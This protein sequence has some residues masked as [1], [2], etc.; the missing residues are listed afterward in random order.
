[1]TDAK[2]LPAPW[3]RLAASAIVFRDGKVLLGERGK[4]AMA[5]FWSLPGGHVEPGEPV[6]V[7]ARREVLEETGVSARILGLVDL[8]EVIWPPPAKDGMRSS[9]TQVA[10]HY[11]IA[12]HYGIWTAGEAVAG[13]DCR[14]ARFFRLDELERLP[15]T[16]GA[17]AIIRRGLTLLEA[18]AN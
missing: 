13:S 2:L 18:N 8:H 7:A 1:M 4:G 14:T 12:V 16:E 10:S 6:A 5:G 15:L 11:V 3:P 17:E 9:D